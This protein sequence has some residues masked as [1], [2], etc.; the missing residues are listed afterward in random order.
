VSGISHA[1]WKLLAIVI[2]VSFLGACS[3]S[4][5][6]GNQGSTTAPSANWDSITWDQGSWS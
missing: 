1:T 6:T 5:V 2:V 3:K 4:S